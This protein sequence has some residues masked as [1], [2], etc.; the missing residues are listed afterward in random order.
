M[1]LY[2]KLFLTGPKEEGAMTN[3]LLTGFEPFGAFSINS[4]WETASTFDRESVGG[5]QVR[6]LRLPVV[7]GGAFGRLVEEIRTGAP[8][9]VIM[10]GLATGPLVRVEKVAVNGMASPDPDNAG[11]LHLGDLIDP[12]GPP[13]YWS[14][15]PVEEI[16]ARLSEADIPSIVSFS[17]GSYVCNDLFYRFSSYTDRQGGKPLGGFVHLPPLERTGLGGRPLSHLCKALGIVIETVVAS[18]S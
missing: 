15:L 5:A 1:D 8:D 18:C 12:S 3:V 7:Y 2:G 14:G 9:V 17:P 10:T 6:A 16:Q 13:A 11:V 4:S